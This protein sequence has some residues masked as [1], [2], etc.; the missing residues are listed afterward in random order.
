[1]KIC[2]TFDDF[3]FGCK[4]QV[5]MYYELSR[6]YKNFKVT[7]FTIPKYKGGI[8]ITEQDIKSKPGWMEIVQHG[9]YHSKKEFENLTKEQAKIRIQE[10]YFEGMIKGFKPP[11]WAY[12]DGVFEVLFEFGYWVA[13]LPWQKMPQTVKEIKYF[14]IDPQIK[15]ELYFQGHNGNIGG[16]GIEENWEKLTHLPE[17][18][19]VFASELLRTF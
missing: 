3:D 10:G 2:L 8:G 1:M 16:T 17:G 7:L 5:K 19:F 18:E 12:N 14:T 13:I 11:Q 9:L 15:D 6:I 4:D